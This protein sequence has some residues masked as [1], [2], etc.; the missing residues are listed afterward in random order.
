ML[1]S[2]HELFQIFT[3]LYSEVMKYYVDDDIEM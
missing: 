3:K 1:H 2:V